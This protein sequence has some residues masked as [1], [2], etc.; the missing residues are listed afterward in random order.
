MK[1]HNNQLDGL[2]GS[3]LQNT[4]ASAARGVNAANQQGTARSEQRTP[5][6]DRIQLS[7]LSDTLRADSED[8]PQRLAK[9]Q[10]LKE[11][12]ESGTYQGDA[13]VVSSRL[14]DEALGGF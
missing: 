10:Q 6:G 11:A 1:I 8:T 13:A 14:V 3:G 4:G 9:V 5:D 7:R 12:Y 2:N